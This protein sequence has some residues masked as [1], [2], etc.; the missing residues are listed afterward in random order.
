MPGTFIRNAWR[1]APK[2]HCQT[3]GPMPPT[4]EWPRK[5]A[6]AFG[7]KPM[8]MPVLYEVGTLWRCDEC[9]RWWI[10][11]KPSPTHSRGYQPATRAWG[12][13]NRLNPRLRRRITA[14]E[15]QER[16]AS[17]CEYAKF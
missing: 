8:A 9:Q 10:C 6:R 5:V 1:Q 14:Y 12:P 2:H 7:D 13:V 15:Q 11:H 4:T 3:P 16:D 17:A